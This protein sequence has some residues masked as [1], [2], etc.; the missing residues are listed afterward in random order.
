MEIVVVLGLGFVLTAGVV[1]LAVHSQRYRAALKGRAAARGWTWHDAEGRVSWAVEGVHQ[2]LPWRVECRRN[3]RS[4][5][6]STRSVQTR[7][8]AP[9][10][11]PHVLMTGPKLPSMLRG[12]DLGDPKVQLG[13]R[14]LVGDGAELLA[15]AKLQPVEGRFGEHFDVLATTEE[16]AALLDADARAVLLRFAETDQPPI[17][18]CWRDELTVRLRESVDDPDRLDRLVQIGCALLSKL[19]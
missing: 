13:L 4:S 12:I 9:A 2:G 19:A 1:A 8:T 7:F 3:R 10:R 16:A 17:V 5:N 15:S 11:T 18:T 6:A 14:L